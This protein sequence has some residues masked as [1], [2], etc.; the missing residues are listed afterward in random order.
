M[1]ANTIFYDSTTY[2]Y[3]PKIKMKIMAMS[4]I[5]LSNVITIKETIFMPRQVIAYNHDEYVQVDVVFDTTD[6]SQIEQCDLLEKD[7][8]VDAFEKMY[9]DKWI[10]VAIDVIPH[11]DFEQNKM[12]LNNIT[13]II[14]TCCEKEQSISFCTASKKISLK[15]KDEE[16]TG[17]SYLNFENIIEYEVLTVEEK[18][19]IKEYVNAINQINYQHDNKIKSLF[20]NVFN[21][22]VNKTDSPTLNTTTLIN[23]LHLTEQEKQIFDPEMIT[24]SAG[25]T[26]A[27]ET[28]NQLVG[29][30]NVKTEIKKLKSKLTYRKRQNERDILVN[31]FSSMHMCFTGA[32]GTGKTTV[33]RIVAGIL[34]DMGYIKENKCIEINGQNLKGGYQGQTAIITKLIMKSAKNKVLFID[35]AYALFDN[36][37]SGYGKEA[38][39]VILK[40]MEDERDN[41]VVIFAGYKNDMEEFLTM[42]DGLKSRINRYIDFK[43]YSTKELTDILM[44]L[45][46]QKKLYITEDALEK[47]VLA[48][49]KATVTERFSNARFVRNLIEKIEYEHAYNTHGIKDIRRQDTITIEDVTDEIIDELLTHSM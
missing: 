35:E 29:L 3:Q 11:G 39:A 2:K 5:S 28:L 10:W 25:V 42:N 48:F 45:L 32:P 13:S 27:E 9:P 14:K 33:A 17:F 19:F 44:L 24:L 31:D 4:K 36:Y 47:C 26:N 16:T 37:N 12:E 49:K 34:Y 7:I 23:S 46:Q 40:H 1:L 18:L 21:K 43:N 20:S 38:V 8:T 15:V 41:T 6:S 30:D 22:K